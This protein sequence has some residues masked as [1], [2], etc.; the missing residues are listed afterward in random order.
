MSIKFPILSV[1]FEDD[2]P[3]DFVNHWFSEHPD[4][5]MKYRHMGYKYS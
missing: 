1:N 4:L 3:L 2:T 5:T